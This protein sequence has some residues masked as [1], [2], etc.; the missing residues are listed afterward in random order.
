MTTINLLIA[1]LGFVVILLTGFGLRR[2]GQP[3]P[4]LIL[5]VHK[6]VALAT[7]VF[8]VKAIPGLARLTLPGREEW[9]AAI[10][11]GVFFLL[12]I[13]S[14]GWLSAVKSMPAW[15]RVLHLILSFLTIISTAVFLYLM[16]RQGNG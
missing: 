6:L 1:G 12:A 10:A 2:L 5:A 16:Y 14:G 9:I 8:L 15:V 7:V 4:A 3:F 11:A 13:V